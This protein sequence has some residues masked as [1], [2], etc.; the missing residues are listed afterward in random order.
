MIFTYKAI[1]H[2][3][4]KNIKRAVFTEN[5]TEINKYPIFVKNNMSLLAY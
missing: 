5:N 1:I 4:V 2:S 3:V